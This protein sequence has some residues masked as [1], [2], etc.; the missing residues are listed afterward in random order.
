MD[1]YSSI[2]FAS[3]T[4]SV[5]AGLLVWVANR[6]SLLNR[7]WF[8]LSSSIG[9]FLIGFGGTLITDKPQEIMIWQKI[10]YFGGVFCPFFLLHFST[11]L[12][13]NFQKAKKAIWANLAI[14]CI[15]A[16]LF[17][18]TNLL[19]KGIIPS[20]VESGW[21]FELTDWYILLP[22][23]SIILLFVSLA[24]MVRGLKNRSFDPLKKQQIS[25]ILWGTM[26]TFTS[27]YS[28][29]LLDYGI[30]VPPV[31]FLLIPSHFLFAGYSMMK[32]RL[33]DL[34]FIAT[35]LLIIGMGVILIVFSFAMPSLVLQI[36]SLIIFLN[37]I[38][39]LN[40]ESN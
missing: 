15:F 5:I 19:I 12:T 36:S 4:I 7:S 13:E 2:I 18:F 22:I 39:K 30:E 10:V 6:K 26:I 21:I 29:F 34:K 8:W 33:F 25:F 9:I 16:Y 38:L 31:I 35:E 40:P 20:N 17:L 24:I 11:I 1:F 3:G 37:L 27:A 23:W 14:S 32:N 28:T